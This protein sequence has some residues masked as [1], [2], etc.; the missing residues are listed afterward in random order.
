MRYCRLTIFVLGLSA[1]VAVGAQ[2]DSLFTHVDV[3]D[4]LAT[5]TKDVPATWTYDQ[6][7]EW[8][9][10]NN[11]DIRSTILSVLQADQDIAGAKDAWLPSV[12]FSTNHNFSN[13]PSPD[14]GRKNNSYNS[15]YGVNAS[16][17]VWEGNARKYR[18]ESSRMLRMQQQL[19]GENQV[20]E[21]KLAILQA[22]LNILYSRESIEIARQTLEVSTAQAARTRRLVE[23]GR[24]SKVDLAQIESQR[25]QDEYNLVQAESNLASDKMAMKKLL[26]LG[27]DTD[28]EI[29]ETMFADTE[30]TASLPAMD[31]TFAAAAA[32]LPEFKNNELSK[33][34]YANDVKIARAGYMPNIAL[35]GGVGSGYASGG[36]G[37]GTQMKHGFNEYVGVSLSVPIFDGNKTK[38]AVAKAKLAELEY[39]VNR[40]RLLDNLS[41]T[42]ESLYIQAR[43]AQ[44]KYTSGISRLAASE[45]TANLVNRQFELGAVNPLELLTAHNNLLSARLEQLQNK[46]MAILSNKTIEFYNTQQVVLP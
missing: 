28:M 3:A 4:V 2:T 39:D 22:Y 15:S 23:G 46:Y 25:A 33:D 29:A 43:N 7:V 38:R 26:A 18:L 32:W 40:D 19:A 41:Q 6:C 34:V 8:A 36:A 14:N 11:T 35:Q 20:N 21:L 1:A 17:T 9:V 24:S 45:E 13:Y 44:A 31:A 10:K 42:I 30:V 12:D 27:L 37:W 16:W 5:G